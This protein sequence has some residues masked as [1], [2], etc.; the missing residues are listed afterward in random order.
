MAISLDYNLLHQRAASSR[1]RMARLADDLQQ[2]AETVIN[3]EEFV[4]IA[5]RKITE[6]GFNTGVYLEQVIGWHERFAVIR[7]EHVSALMQRHRERKHPTVRYVEKRP[8]F[9]RAK[10]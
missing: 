10:R 8:T 1:E 5:M 6:H 9:K 4:A 2:A 7:R 3:R